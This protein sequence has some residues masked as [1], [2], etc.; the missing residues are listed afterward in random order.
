MAEPLLPSSTLLDRLSPL[1]AY[2]D[3][4]AYFVGG[5]VRDALLGRPVHD[6]D[7]AVESGAMDLAYELADRLG[8]PV[9]PLDKERDV[10]RIVAAQESTTLDI[11][12]FRGEDL[13]ADLRGRDF[14]I[15]AMALPAGAT[16]PDQ[17]IDPH[18]GRID[19]AAR[20]LQPVHERSI[21]EDPVRALRAVRLAV[22]LDFRLT[23]DTSAAAKAAAPA[24]PARISAERI[25]DELIRLLDLATPDAGIHLLDEL[26]LLAAI[27][28]EIAA[29]K[30]LT[31][32]PPHHEPVF[33]HS[34]SALHRLVDIERWLHE[35]DSAVEFA[36]IE[37]VAGVYRA[38]LIEHLNRGVDGGLTIR[39]LLR[40]GTLLHDAGKALTQTVDPDGRIRFLRHDEVGAAVARQR[41]NALNF[42]NEATRHVGEIVAGHM[43]PLYLA[44]DKRPPSRR[45]I[46]RFYRS[47][48]SAGLSIP[49]LALADHLATYDGIGDETSWRW[50]LTVI[51]SL[52]ESYF[53]AYGETVRPA[54][55]LTGVEVMGI[56]KF[57]GGPEIGRLLRLLE[58]AQA[59]GE[60]ATKAEAIAFVRQQYRTP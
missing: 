7:I 44:S 57:D 43:R 13:L 40:W 58:E 8:L 25:R 4:P 23:A 16:T 14:T 28:P 39:Q 22:Q 29:L 18:D 10:G 17:I 20:R 27:L 47:L 48:P 55:L 49:L 2:R 51:G 26:G 34:L 37:P 38:G 9:Y 50:L 46:Y 42:S 12:R 21:A 15:N 59:A 19:L 30:G 31:Q 56:L 3:P 33:E 5:V 11:A 24:I 1:I 45:T 53:T 52:Y 35:P 6:I 41:L 54:R 32:S 60:I 36:A